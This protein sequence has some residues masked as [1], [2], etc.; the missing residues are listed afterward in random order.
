MGDAHFSNE[1]H[2]KNRRKKVHIA[3][4]LGLL[5]AIAI[6]IGIGVLVS[7][8]AETFPQAP[9]TP[10]ETPYT[11]PPTPNATFRSIVFDNDLLLNKNNAEWQLLDTAIPKGTDIDIS[12]DGNCVAT[13]RTYLR[14]REKEEDD[15]GPRD[16]SVEMMGRTSVTC[17]T[18]DG[19]WEP[20]GQEIELPETGRVVSLSGDGKRV[21]IGG[22]LPRNHWGG[23]PS[24]KGPY[25]TGRQV[26]VYEYDEYMKHWNQ[27]GQAL[28]GNFTYNDGF[29]AL[30]GDVGMNHDGSIVWVAAR[31]TLD[32]ETHFPRQKIGS[33][34]AYQYEFESNIWKPMG[35]PISPFRP[36]YLNYKTISSSASG[37]RLVTSHTQHGLSIYDYNSEKKEWV[38]AL[39]N[40]TDLSFTEPIGNSAMSRNGR[41]LAVAKQIRPEG[42]DKREFPRASNAQDC[43]HWE[44]N[45]YDSPCG[46]KYC[47][48]ITVLENVEGNIWRRIGSG[49][50]AE[51]SLDEDICVAGFI[52]NLDLNFDGSVLAVGDE[53][54]TG[55]DGQEYFSTQ[56]GTAFAFQYVPPTTERRQYWSPMGQPLYGDSYPNTTHM[57]NIIKL[58]ASGHRFAVTES[59]EYEVRPSTLVFELTAT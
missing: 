43:T 59:A 38:H 16:N 33:V 23:G 39:F 17:W 15:N 28:F 12:D 45:C 19:R 42:T 14:E 13:T 7:S 35:K 48:N 11:L 20:L 34:R 2:A 31:L 27:I 3:I 56:Y 50:S 54:S 41:I 10:T 25:R 52:P 29:G 37:K 44:G 47:T 26:Y 24:I 18:Q 51:A 1:Q 9:E 21:A 57:G 5:C 4:L 6:S 36:A 58:S 55:P 49:N 40:G 32:N 46:F 8:K 22:T 53:S 30:P